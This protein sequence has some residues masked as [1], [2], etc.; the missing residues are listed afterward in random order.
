MDWA[1]LQ[2]WW[3][4]RQGLDGSVVGMSAS[5]ALAK[6]GWARSVGGAN[7][8]ITLFARTGIGKEEAERAVAEVQIHE[9]PSARGCTHFLPHDH[10]ALG[11][12]VGQG[13]SEEAAM[14]T[15][16]KFLGVTDAEIDRLGDKVLEALQKGELDPA[17]LKKAVGDAVRNL[18]DE[19]KKRGQTTTLPLSLGFLQARGQIRRLPIGGRLDSQRYKYALWSPSP[20]DGFKMS[21]EEARAELARLYF[22]WIGPAKREHFQWFSG[23]GV[24]A[25][26]DAISSLK[27]VDIGEGY[28]LP[29]ELK[30]EFD[31]FAAPKDERIALVASLD[32]VL[33]LRRE[34]GCL[35]GPEDRD[36]E[37]FTD[38]SVVPITGLQD[39]YCNAIVDR[40]RL[41]GLWEFD[42]E[43]QELVWHT[44]QPATQAIKDAVAR[45]EKFAQEQ[46]GDVRSFS[47]DSPKS[48][49]PKLEA[50]RKMATA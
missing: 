41:V 38:K 1:R 44:F 50:L 40:G 20:L 27:L 13:F 34:V 46:L 5:E 7:P 43:A 19:G 49:L 39:I 21:A 11:L 23:L 9:L 29:D 18:G 26:Q 8:Y 22:G 48:R 31:D 32:S 16:R 6:V 36:R 17:E 47:L 4:H 24:R 28:L 25:S 2:A 14:Q 37:T 10:Y 3:A 15:A 45:T 30:A 42:S 12:K 35:L 33:L